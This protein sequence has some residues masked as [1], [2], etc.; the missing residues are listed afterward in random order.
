MKALL[1][2]HRDSYN[3]VVISELKLECD[4]VR[5]LV[6]I[7]TTDSDRKIVVKLKELA[8]AID[9]FKLLQD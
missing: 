1:K 2:I 6:T 4:E 9:M 5:G 8:G 7:N 3:T